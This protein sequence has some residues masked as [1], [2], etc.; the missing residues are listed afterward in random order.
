MLGFVSFTNNPNS[1]LYLVPPE[2]IRQLGIG[3]RSVMI[4][5]GFCSTYSTHTNI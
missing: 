3:A 2:K 5:Y 4:F 1:S